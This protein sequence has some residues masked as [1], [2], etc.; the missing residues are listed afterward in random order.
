MSSN[1]NWHLYILR[2]TEGKYYV[3]ITSKTP[4]ER[5]LEHKHK[6]RPAYWTI[7]YL[8]QEV[9]YTEN[10]GQIPKEKAEKRE[11]RMV[12]ACIKKYGLNNVRGG[13]FRDTE[14]Y[15]VRF[16]WFVNKED[17][18]LLVNAFW[19]LVLLLAFYLDKYVYVFIPGG[20]R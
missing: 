1:K 14:D 12:R 10:L 17:W 4:E 18:K 8:P 19:L 13:D 16:G 9:I 15:I 3:G 5:F 6:I 20:I 7:K 11:N 2:C